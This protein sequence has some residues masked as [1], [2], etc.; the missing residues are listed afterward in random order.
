MADKKLTVDQLIN[1]LKKYNHKEL[2]V[3]HTWKPRHSNF[4]GRNHQ[5]LQN[6]MRN[7]HVNTNGWQDIAQHVTLYPD[8]TFL[9]GRD[10]NTTPASIR[11]YNT[12]AFMVEM[13]GNFDKGNDKLEGKQEASIVKLAQ[14]FDSRGKYIRFHRE[15]ASKSCPGTGISKTE[16]M[17]KVK[18]K[19]PSR[20]PTASRPVSSLLRKGDRGANVKQLQNDLISAGYTVKFGADGIFGAGTESAVRQLQSDYKISVDGI[21]GNDTRAKLKLAQ[22]KK[23]PSTSVKT[24]RNYVSGKIVRD[25][26]QELNRQFNKGLAVDGYFGDNTIN[27]LVNVRTGA[28]GNLTRIIQERLNAKGYKLSRDGIFG[29]GTAR[30]VRQFQSKNGLSADGVVGKNTWT[31]L[32]SK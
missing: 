12:G 32:Y 11:G 6:G 5:V 25:L 7:Y 10:F 31:K 29:A 27:A 22:N 18:G 2:H 17:A 23:A 30:A 28:R 3:H 15:N 9:T 24:W 8:G 13:I 14:Y 1:L 21:V 4:N 26:Q 20:Q 19:T 16:F